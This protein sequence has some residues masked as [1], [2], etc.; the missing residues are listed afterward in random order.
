MKATSSETGASGSM[1]PED[2]K[3]STPSS[4]EAAHGTGLE[5][6][7]KKS[8]SKL[9]GGGSRE[10]ESG[11]SRSN[12]AIKRS[13]T[14][15]RSASAKSLNPLRRIF[16]RSQ[17]HHEAAA[18]IPLGSRSGHASPHNGGSPEVRTRARGSSLMHK[19]AHHQPVLIQSKSSS[20]LN[21]AVSHNVNPFISVRGADSP[22]SMLGTG[23]DIAAPRQPSSAV[24]NALSRKSSS[25]NSNMVYNP[26]GTL[27]KSNTSSSQH[28]ISFYLQDGKDEMPLLPLPLEDPNDYLPEG[29]KQYS[30]HLADNFAYPER[31]SADDI[32]LGS[33]GSSEVR[34]VRSLFHKKEIYALKKFKLLRKEKPD[35]FY[36]RCSKEFIIAKRLSNNLHIANTYY[37]VKV[38]T[39]TSMTRGWAFVMEYCSGGDLFSVISKP[40]WKKR[41]LKEKFSLWK[42][43]AEGLLYMHQQGVVHRDL[44]PENV[45]MSKEGVAKLTDFGISDWAHEDPE[46]L[47]SPIKMF[48]CYVGSPPYSP[49][50]VMVLQD[51]N[52]AKQDK[53]PYDAHKMDCWALGMLMFTLVY[54]STPFF[55]AYRTD[56]KFRA[57]VLSYDN[58]VDHMNPHFRKAGN[59]RPGPGSEFQYGREFHDGNASRVAWRLADPNAET[60]YTMQSLVEDPWWATIDV[61][62]DKA[63]TPVPKAP[64]IRRSST[65][66]GVPSPI[67]SSSANRSEEDVAHTSNPF[68]T[69]PKSKQKSML[70]I[71]EGLPDA[72]LKGS[73]KPKG[74]PSPAEQLPTLS[75]EKTR[76]DAERDAERDTEALHESKP[77]LEKVAEH[78]EDAELGDVAHDNDSVQNTKSQV[79]ATTA[80]LATLVTQ[81]QDE[82]FEDAHDELESAPVGAK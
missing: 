28:D 11:S 65:E 71:A 2:I 46:D 42:Q 68:L 36:K 81:D 23:T 20:A 43:V 44:K 6:S 75:E 38:A 41:P 51:K 49:P 47:S 1:I 14:P 24:P 64:E 31:N 79:E 72:K 60:R 40:D 30:I 13:S 76:E 39:S 77:R 17:S 82:R 35:H 10:L 78:G 18:G 52:A 54:Q 74:S 59:Y 80:A 16:R 58:F 5:H 27:S 8:G 37:L 50:E 61:P 29:F 45:L 56:S 55:D 26:Y 15:H 9:F 66:S 19:N 4:A 73:L 48:E 25:N 67:G 70:S 33:G 3:D 22:F 7:L 34:T 21:N 53:K 63:E 12:N 57:Y 69:K 62:C 32:A